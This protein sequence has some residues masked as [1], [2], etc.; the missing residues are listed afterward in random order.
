MKKLYCVIWGKYRK[1]KN[2]NISYIFENKIIPSIICSECSNEDEKIFKEESLEIL[3][4]LSL[5]KNM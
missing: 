1:L 2:R 5:I 3:N 4:I